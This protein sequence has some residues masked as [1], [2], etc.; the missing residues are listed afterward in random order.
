M[1]SLT[2]WFPWLL[3]SFTILSG[4][5]VWMLVMNDTLTYWAGS[6]FRDSLVTLFTACLL[7]YL[8][9]AVLPLLSHPRR[10][11]GKFALA[12]LS[13]LT[14]VAMLLI[15]TFQF[16]TREV[17]RFRADRISYSGESD[18]AIMQAFTDHDFYYP[19]ETF[20]EQ[21]RLVI[22]LG[23]A[24]LVISDI[25]PDPVNYALYPRPV[26]VLPDLQ[27]AALANAIESWSQ[28]G[29]PAFPEGFAAWLQQSTSNPAAIAR[30]TEAMIRLRDIRWVVVVDAFN[31]SNNRIVR[32]RGD[33]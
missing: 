3:C 1:N 16:L 29:D 25:R 32:I 14:L 15:G 7:L 5:G 28:D 23:E 30:E 9:Q 17:P 6:S 13:T 11:S 8:L 24:V 10:F 4:L 12:I 26:Y 18:L 21:A 19:P 22:P 31:E 33:R 2:R 20:L 27:R